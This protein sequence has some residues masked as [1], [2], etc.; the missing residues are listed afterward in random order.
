MRTAPKCTGNRITS[1][2]G[3]VSFGGGRA[4]APLWREWRLRTWNERLLEHFFG[5]RNRESTPVVVLLVTP[6]ELKTA[7]GDF[8]ADA[9]AVRNAFVSAVR[10]E[11]ARAGSLFE[12]AS[13]YQ[14]WPGPPPFD[15]PPR[16]V[17]HLA[18]TC[19][20]ASESSDE[21]GDE[22]SFVSRLRELA[23]GRVPDASLQHLR[24]LWEQLAA[25]LSEN[26]HAYR[27]LRLPDPGG[28]TRIGYSV[29]LAFPDRRDQKVLSDL[30]ARAGLMG[31]EPPV[32]KIL[33]LVASERSA[34]RR[35]FIAAHDE[36][37]R[38]F[39]DAAGKRIARLAEH[40]FWAA[41]REASLRGRGLA[42]V[43][44][45]PARISLLSDEV[46]DNLVPFVVADGSFENPYARALELHRAYG[47]WAFA[48]V[49]S[50]ATE[51]ATDSLSEM[52]TLVLNGSLRFPGVAAQIDQGIIPFARE[53]HGL[54][55]VAPQDRLSDVTDVLVRSDLVD[56]Y[57]RLFRPT[58]VRA[59][60]F[61]G[62]MHALGSL[63]TCAAEDLEGTAL[64]RAW[65]LHEGVMPAIALRL[66][67]GVRA[68]DGWL[69]FAEVLPRVIAPDASTVELVASP[70]KTEDLGRAHEGVWELPSRD[71][72]GHYEIVVRFADRPITRHRVRFYSTPASETF[73]EVSDSEAYIVEGCGGTTTLAAA[74]PF[75]STASTGDQGAH[76]E[77]SA[78]LGLDVGRFVSDHDEATWNVVGFGKKLELSK[79][80]R[81]RAELRPGGQVASAHARRRWRKL[82]LESRASSWD[83]DAEEA[84]SNVRANFSAQRELPRL[85]VEQEVPDLAPPTLPA[86]SRFAERL[87]R[88]VCARA[89]ARAVIAWHDWAELARRTLRVHASDLEHITR[90]WMEA[91]LIDSVS[92]A[93]WRY[94]AI[95]GRS[96][97]LVAFRTGTRFG[98]TVSGLLLGTTK[99]LLQDAATR[100]GLPTEERRSVS[101]F[102]PST[103]TLR[104]PNQGALEELSRRTK[105]PLRWLDIESPES[106]SSVRHAGVTDPPSQYETHVRWRHWSL[107]RADLSTIDFL[108]CTR[109]DR[110]DFWQVRR[111]HFGVWSFDLNVARTW[112]ATLLHEPIV[113]PIDS[114][115]VEVVHAYLPLPLARAVNALSQGLAGPVG[116]GRY[117]YV[118]STSLRTLTEKKLARSFDASNLDPSHPGK[119]ST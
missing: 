81:W 104:A 11:I 97:S 17:A 89:A 72:V 9:D 39:E 33:T 102:V 23:D 16:F 52:M 91:G 10:S 67:G 13:D 113:R 21:L 84:R 87:V 49:P 94:R 51:L 36:F 79:G 30:V 46:D 31:S 15:L 24:A 61:A 48:L 96:P 86:P 55:E 6:E 119:E 73:K 34:F 88:V 56:D 20:A 75:S 116:D 26:S 82:L 101:I 109:R 1:R 105:I 27:P 83:P 22:H 92:Y 28:L 117:R 37:R 110:P 29:K 111:D 18:F 106:F 5:R 99:D 7:V 8:D 42:D 85:Q 53:T 40:R 3:D 68:D 66:A 41:V 50:D 108:H 115:F 80:P 60:S 93:R 38:L 35:P 58:T 78:S 12:D 103:L 69:G 25:W 71:L 76:C 114:A 2:A 107:T 59:S 100:L 54:L 64:A 95:V 70:Q 44:S 63:R 74:T 4:S 32:G 47:E 98:A 118:I 43:V 90:A 45:V 62:W 65:I 112:G 19:I 57:R 14:G 77:R